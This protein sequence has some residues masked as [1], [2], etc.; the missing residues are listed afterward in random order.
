MTEPGFPIS[1]DP[2]ARWR[3]GAIS[4]ALVVLVG[5]V[6]CQVGTFGFVNLDDTEYV[7]R[8]PWVLR[9]LTWEG[10][11]WA[12]TGFRVSNWHPVTWLS[13]MLD[14]Q[15]L[16]AS[17]GAHH[18]V[19]VGFHAANTVLLFLLLRGAT[20]ATWRSAA[21]AALFGIHPLR[22]ESVAWISERKDVL[23]TLFLLL[24]LHAWIRYGRTG[25]AGAWIASFLL[26]AIGLMAKPML[27]TTPLLLLLL[28]AWPLG[29]LPVARIAPFLRALPGL[30]LEKAPFLALAA[31]ASAITWMAQ[32]SGGGSAA[33][34]P[35]AFWPRMANAILSCVRYPALALWPSGL[36]SFYPHPATTQASTPIVSAVA[37]LLVIATITVLA[38]RLRASRPYVAW[39]WFWYLGTLLPVIG[40]VQ[41]G[42]QAMADRYT[43]VP[44]I[45]LTVAAVWGL[46]DVLDHWRVPRTVGAVLAVA[47]IAG[48]A[49][50]AHHQVGYWEDSVKLHERSLEVTHSNWKAAH[51][52]CEA[53]LE[54]GLLEEASTACAQ[55]ARFLPTFPEAWQTLGVVRAR[56]GDTDQAM[57][58]FRRA[59]ELRPD[60]FLALRN[61][62][63]AEANSGDLEQ[64][65]RHFQAAL[66]LRPEDPEA[67]HYLG[68]ARLRL[69]DRA[70]AEEA[71][72]RLRILDPILAGK[73]RQR[74]GP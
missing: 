18:L 70:G 68:L 69:G 59:L 27:V 64:A 3:D 7:S 8:N 48:Y 61:L 16:G 25:R 21:T 52:L 37:A 43:Y 73:L 23:S 51:G 34:A 12:F 1:G 32:S 13:H 56:M 26:L 36:A 66:R 74:M 6:Y 45:G 11:R 30:L 19:N 20:G 42:G 14:V 72:A 31:G 10:A 58:L 44:L 57:L 28:D 71:Y 55:A 22:V 29:R 54:Q 9:G 63:S 46:G 24:A 40:I 2:Q 17:P 41:V 50:V 67:W 4:V 15:L 65:I 49:V 47:A 53:L 62:G 39:G 5:A 60:Y 33:V 38:V 35:I